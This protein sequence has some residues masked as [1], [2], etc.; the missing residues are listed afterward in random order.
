M[1]RGTAVRIALAVMASTAAG[2]LGGASAGELDANGVP[3]PTP[4][5]AAA[6]FH[7]FSLIEDL[8][9][10][11]SGQGSA[12]FTD[13]TSEKLH[14]VA[15]YVAA[16]A[17]S[18]AAGPGEVQQ[19]IRCK[20]ANTDL[21]LGGAWTI[22]GGA[23]AGTWTEE[24]YSLSGKLSGRSVPTGFDLKATSTFADASVAVRLS[25]CT[26]DIVM[27]FSQDVDRLHVALRKC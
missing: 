25:G 2:I 9:G 18:G 7:D 4:V 26:Q 11:W 21:K 10:R 23:I 1:L 3:V 27:T 17:R 19:V 14:C 8:A 12:L 5:S 24:T 16:A 20:G 6:S 22:R 15:T 13:G